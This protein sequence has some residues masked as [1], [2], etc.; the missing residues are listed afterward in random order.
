MKPSDLRISAMASLIFECGTWHS[1][2]RA[3]LALRRRVRKSL[4]GSVM[5]DVV[6][7]WGPRGSYPTPA[8]RVVYQDHL[9]TPGILPERASSRNWMRDTPNLRLLPSGR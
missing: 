6:G 2:M 8:G 1:T 7:F 5:V 4:I 9:M 3:L